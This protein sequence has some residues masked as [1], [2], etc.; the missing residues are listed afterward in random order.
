M[1]SSNIAMVGSLEI[2]L[3]DLADLYKEIL[4]NSQM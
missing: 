2:I 3:D 1:A 4:I